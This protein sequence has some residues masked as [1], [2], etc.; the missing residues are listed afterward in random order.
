MNHILIYANAN[1]ISK[2]LKQ[3]ALLDLFRMQI[4]QDS[5]VRLKILQTLA[6]IKY[7]EYILRPFKS[8][9]QASPGTIP[10]M[11]HYENFLN[12]YRDYRSIIAAFINAVN[13]MDSQRFED[14]AQF[15]CVACEYNERIISTLDLRMKGMHHGFLLENRRKCLKIWNEFTIRKFTFKNSRTSDVSNFE[16]TGARLQQLNQQDLNSLIEIMI[17]KFLPCFFR[18]YNSTEEDRAM[19]DEIRQDWLNVLDSNLPGKFFSLFLVKKILN[20]INFY[21]KFKFS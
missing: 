9:G 8:P 2:E 16:Q 10:I 21:L 6:Q 3:I 12:D 20:F 1:I 15:F 19:I 14:A 18:L 13:F 11:K 5:D 4:F 17:N 7:N